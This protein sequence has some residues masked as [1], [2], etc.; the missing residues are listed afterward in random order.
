MPTSSVVT[1][2]YSLYLSLILGAG[3][4][5]VGLLPEPMIFLV[6]VAL[7][8]CILAAAVSFREWRW[9]PFRVGEARMAR[10]SV[11]CVTATTVALLLRGYPMSFVLTP[12]LSVVAA[13]IV[14]RELTRGGRLIRR[15][16]R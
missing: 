15:S 4:T 1:K 2:R 12:L 8:A 11:C 7:M 5:C 13:L 16:K 9:V 6:G 14:F 3:I 10:L